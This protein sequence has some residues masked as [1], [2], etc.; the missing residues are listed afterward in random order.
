[1]P[2]KKPMWNV[3]RWL[4]GKVTKQDGSNVARQ[5]YKGNVWV[6]CMEGLA[7]DSEPEILRLLNRPEVS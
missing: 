2:K 3:V 7:P 6:C 5:L 4:D 1:M